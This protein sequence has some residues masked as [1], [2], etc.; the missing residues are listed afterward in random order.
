MRRS[1]VLEGDVMKLN[2]ILLAGAAMLVGTGAQAQT[3]SNSNANGYVTTTALP[4]TF[5]LTGGDNG[6]GTFGDTLYTDT[7]MG[8]LSIA[9]T[10][11]YQS[12]DVDG[13][14]FDPA[15]YILGG[16][17]FQLSNSGASSNG[18]FSFNVGAGQTYGFYVH[19]TDNRFG[20]GRISVV[21]NAFAAATGA[22]PEPATW[23][24]MLAGFG[25]IGFAARKRSS[26]KTAVSYA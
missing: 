25:M 16:T 10:F 4:G 17:L 19:T 13:G 14:V 26:V 11:N 6:S 15:G 7:A 9:G 22:V 12:F 5:S 21:S 1:A 23:A 2:I 20:P 18:N 8:P 24:M 3:L